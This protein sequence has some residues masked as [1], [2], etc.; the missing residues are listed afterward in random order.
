MFADTLI[1]APIYLLLSRTHTLHLVKLSVSRLTFVKRTQHAASICQFSASVLSSCQNAWQTQRRNS[2]EYS[3]GQQS[4]SFTS[5]VGCPLLDM[6]SCF[7]EHDA[8]VGIN[9]FCFALKAKHCLDGA[10]PQGV[11]TLYTAQGLIM[12]ARSGSLLLSL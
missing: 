11:A 4:E 10:G 2:S 3:C 5:H 8:K 6:H 9:D 1:G 12:M 7:D